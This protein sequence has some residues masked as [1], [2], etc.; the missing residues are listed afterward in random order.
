[1]SDRLVSIIIPVHNQLDY[2]LAC[3][4]SIRNANDSTPH[5]IIVVDDCSTDATAETIS[6]MRDV[7]YVRNETNLGFLKSINS[8]ADGAHGE[9]LM[10]LNNDT[11]VKDG[12]LQWLLRIFEGHADAA[13][14]GSKLFYPDGT[15]QEAGAHLF[16]DGTAFNYGRQQ[17]PDDYR[18]N[19]VR[20]VDYCSGA[21][22]L[23]RRDIF[24]K[25]GKFD[26]LFCPAYCE[27][28]DFQLRA[29]EAGFSIYYQPLSVVIHHEG[30]SHGKALSESSR[31]K[32][33]QTENKRKLLERH[34]QFLAGHAHPAGTWEDIAI[35]PQG[36]RHVYV[37]ADHLLAPDRDSRDA[38]TFEIMKELQ[39]HAQVTFIPL[40]AC[41]PYSDS[42]F[43]RYYDAIAQLGVRPFMNRGGDPRVPARRLVRQFEKQPETVIFAGSAAASHF[44]QAL[45]R[46]R[47]NGVRVILDVGPK[48]VEGDIEEAIETYLF[49]QVDEVW[50]DPTPSVLSVV[51]K[52]GVSV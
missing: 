27:D 12:Y 49:E 17:N 26:E 38:R 45:I 40:E 6:K 18:Y 29:L 32:Q 22:V 50:R 36:T 48:N 2:T 39:N 23:I 47:A 9:F 20:K 43:L 14:A 10:L 4:Q 19:Y 28:S 11:E 25:L 46:W 1:M 21:A 33:Y 24:F 31:S 41:Y 52:E 7:N 15:L 51:S 5:E 30:V 42:E 8:G 44:H 3:L 37:V 35:F 34:E 16:Q 13:A